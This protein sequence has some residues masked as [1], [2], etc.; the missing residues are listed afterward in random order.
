MMMPLFLALWVCPGYVPDCCLV[1]ATPHLRKS[2]CSSL[3]LSFPNEDYSILFSPHSKLLTILVKMQ[4]NFHITVMQMSS[5]SFIPLAHQQMPAKSFPLLGS[6]CA[7]GIF[8]HL[9]TALCIFHQQVSIGSSLCCRTSGQRAY[10]S[11][12]VF[13]NGYSVVF[14]PPAAA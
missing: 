9:W 10:I 1:R 3:V 14:F 12:K 8:K 11:S 6:L 13:S 5:G 7:L 2:W 4:L